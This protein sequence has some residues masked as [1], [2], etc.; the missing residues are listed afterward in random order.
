M[1]LG[2]GG[3]WPP[4]EDAGAHSRLW[5]PVLLVIRLIGGGLVLGVNGDVA[6][7]SFVVIRP[8]KLLRDA[9]EVL[10]GD[11][12][13]AA[14]ETLCKERQEA[15]KSRQQLPGLQIS[16]PQEVRV[17]QHPMLHRCTG[18]MILG[19]RESRVLSMEG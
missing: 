16:C 2:R 14:G 17:M 5:G 7:P 10:V 12:I 15:G 9:Q 4:P 8:V 3:P 1:G 18:V 6:R 13:P 11:G 19:C